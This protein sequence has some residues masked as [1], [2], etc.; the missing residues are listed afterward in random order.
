MQSRRID[1]GLLDCMIAPLWEKFGSRALRWAQ[2]CFQQQLVA[3]NNS[4]YSE[5]FP[6]DSGRSREFSFRSVVHQ[7]VV[8]GTCCPRSGVAAAVGP[9]SPEVWR[10]LVQPEFPTQIEAV[11]RDGIAPGCM[12]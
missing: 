12:N 3:A 10:N 2:L 11:H 6:V 4:P 5:A 9:T 1:F 7:Q 8:S